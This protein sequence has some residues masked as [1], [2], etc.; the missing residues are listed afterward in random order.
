MDQNQK[1]KNNLLDYIEENAK[2]IE[3]L[4]KD[5]NIEKATNN[6]LSSEKDQ[7]KTLNNTLTLENKQVNEKVQELHT[8]NNDLID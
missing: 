6:Q 4:S 1:E 5:L 8:G 7:L 2:Q 3:I